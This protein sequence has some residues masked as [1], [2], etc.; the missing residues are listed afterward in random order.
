MFAAR[1]QKSLKILY[2]AKALQ[3]LNDMTGNFL[4][5]KDSQFENVD[6]VLVTLYIWTW[7]HFSLEIKK[8]SF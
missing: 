3:E 8:F 1:L 4:E 6:D 2:V 7:S 5:N